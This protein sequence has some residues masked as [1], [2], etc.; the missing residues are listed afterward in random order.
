M[1]ADETN[2]QQVGKLKESLIELMK[3]AVIEFETVRKN[4]QRTVGTEVIEI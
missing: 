4:K 1:A 3:K 2:K